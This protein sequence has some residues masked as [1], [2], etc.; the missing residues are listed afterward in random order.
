MDGRALHPELRRIFRWIPNP[1]VRRPWQAR[2]F[3]AATRRIPRRTPPDVTYARHELKPGVAVDIYTPSETQGFDRRTA[4]AALLWVH[5]GGLIVGASVQ[6][7]A[8]CAAT[9]QRTGIVVVSIDYRLAIDLPFP[10]AL[11]DCTT[12][13]DWLQSEAPRLSIDPDRVLVGGQSAGAGLAAALCQRLHDRSGPQPIGQWLFSPML[14]DRTAALIE[15]DSIRHFM[16]NNRS[17]RIGWSRYLDHEP[18][19][20]EPLPYAVPAR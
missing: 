5:G 2:L 13:W 9:A 14:D 20:G 4:K 15:L 3:T 10:A 8:R 1:P 19:S 18:G 17:N 12:A 6:D 16:W 11:D 7:H